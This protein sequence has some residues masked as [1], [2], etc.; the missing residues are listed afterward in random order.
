[1]A[2]AHI[3]LQQFD[4]AE[5]LLADAFR[6]CRQLDN[7]HDLALCHLYLGLLAQRRAQ[8]EQATYH[9][10]ALATIATQVVLHFVELH[11]LLAEL[12][13]LFYGRR[14]NLAYHLLQMLWQSIRH[15]QL[16][17]SDLRR[18]SRLCMYTWPSLP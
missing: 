4:A 15:D 6:I 3:G 7:Q 9:W 13:A 1:M 18:F 2:A 8:P 10:Q 14:Y 17:L 12:P 16:S 11:V 5:A